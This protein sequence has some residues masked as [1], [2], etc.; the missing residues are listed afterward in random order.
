MLH[1]LGD[2][3]VAFEPIGGTNA[4]LVPDL[5]TSIPT[6]TDGGRTYTFELR[7]GIGYSNGEVVAPADFRRALE[8]GFALNKVAHESL[9]GG[10]VGAEA[11]GKE[12]RTCDLSGGIVTDD[13]TGT[14]TFHLVGPDPEFLYKLT[15]PFAYPV[16]P[17]LPDEHQKTAGIPGAGPYML[18]APMTREGLA[19]V[20]NPHFRV[21]SPAAQP[22]GYADRIEWA[23][24]VEPQAQVEAVAAGDADLAFDASAS[25]RLEDI[26]VRYAAQVYASPKP[27]TLFVVLDTEAPP[28]DHAEVRRAMNLVIDRARVVE[29]FGGEGTMRPTCQ[30]L[31][32]NFP[33]YEPY[34]PYTMEPGPG[35]EGVWAAPSV[36]IEEAREIVRRSGTAGMRVVFEY[37]PTSGTARGGS[38]GSTWS[39]YSTSWDTAET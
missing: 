31:P 25:D 32:P 3:L 12:P 39:S 23:F 15:L 37:P 28:F 11:C 10:L 24:G 26:F 1:L 20:R 16:P 2:G 8:R 6:P 19:R 34:C 7:S 27:Q 9:Y 5:A 17:S 4:T 33:G 29:I 22:D 14:I 36:D 13:V 38:W 21:W 35:G 30:Q 18:E